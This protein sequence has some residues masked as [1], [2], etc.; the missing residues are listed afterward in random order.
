MR[1]SPEFQFHFWRTARNVPV[2]R[3]VIHWER[4]KVR[5][6]DGTI[7]RGPRRPGLACAGPLYSAWR[8]TPWW[9]GRASRC[10]FILM[11]VR[12]VCWLGLVFLPT[13]SKR[14]KAR[15]GQILSPKRS[16]PPPRLR[17]S[18]DGA[19]VA[20]SRVGR[21]S[22]HAERRFARAESCQS[23]LGSRSTLPF[24]CAAQEERY[25]SCVRSGRPSDRS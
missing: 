18:F 19:T 16:L 11:A 10:P 17:G 1:L 25:S 2:R 9:P 3:G 4:R 15:P 22:A 5:G 21:L 23:V 12:L 6:S 24:H 7:P 14:A 20:E 13:I 8:L